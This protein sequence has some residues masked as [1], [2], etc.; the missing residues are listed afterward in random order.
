MNDSARNKS[1]LESCEEQV[2]EY[3]MYLT[4][5]QTDNAP[6]MPTSINAKTRRSTRHSAADKTASDTEATPILSKSLINVS[7]ISI[8]S[9][10]STPVPNI[11]AR[12]RKSGINNDL[13]QSFLKLKEEF[14]EAHSPVSAV[15]KQD[16][17]TCSNRSRTVRTPKYDEKNTS[18]KSV[19][20]SINSDDDMFDVKERSFK[21][22]LKML[23]PSS[24]RKSAKKS[25]LLSSMTST[26]KEKLTVVAT[27]VS[28]NK[29]GVKRQLQESME[30]QSN[31]RFKLGKLNPEI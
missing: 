23:A 7:H 11:S 8:I 30:A 3:D 13:S 15:E 12:L 9:S 29:K 16:L 19:N 25:I 26:P 1:T 24:T 22:P 4:P 5:V 10:P 21:T 18:L 28:T 31:K 6:R 2:D 27:A 14:D 20:R 17:S